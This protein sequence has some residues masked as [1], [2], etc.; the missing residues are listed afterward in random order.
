MLKNMWRFFSYESDGRFYLYDCFSLKLF[1]IQKELYGLLKQHDGYKIKKNFPEFYKKIIKEK[2]VKIKQDN[3]NVCNVT[4]NFSNYCNLDC[5]YCYRNKKNKNHMDKQEIK[6]ILSFILNDYM[7]NASGYVF[8]LCY[9]S[10]STLDLEDLIYFDSLIA[11]FEGHLF[12]KDD[13]SF[14]NAK[15]IFNA[16]PNEIKHK[17]IYK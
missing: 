1:S 2:Q 12:N 10:E 17:Y 8:S 16:L 13:L 7:P 3:D 9:T 5:V 4:I 11:E 14:S 15:M 6:N